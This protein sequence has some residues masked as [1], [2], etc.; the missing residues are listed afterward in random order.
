MKFW[1]LWL[2]SKPA[3]RIKMANTLVVNLVETFAAYNSILEKAGT[4]RVIHLKAEY[5]NHYFEDLENTIKLQ[6]RPR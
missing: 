4:E 6:K 5:L 1:E 2:I 3:D